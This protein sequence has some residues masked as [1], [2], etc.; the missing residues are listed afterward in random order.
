MCGGR[1]NMNWVKKSSFDNSKVRSDYY[2]IL[3]YLISQNL[4]VTKKLTS[5]IQSGDIRTSHTLLYNYG[6]NIK[7]KFKGHSVWTIFQIV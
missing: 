6:N 7:R 4:D 3:A 5:F 2:D 1:A